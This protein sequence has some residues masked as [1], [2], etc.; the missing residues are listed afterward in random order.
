MPRER[1]ADTRGRGGSGSTI[2]AQLAD[3]ARPARAAARRRRADHLVAVDARASA[4]APRL[5]PTRRRTPGSVDVL[6]EER[7]VALGDPREEALSVAS[8]RGSSGR[9]SIS[10]PSAGRARRCARR[11]IA[12]APAACCLNAWRPATNVT[13][14][15]PSRSS[16]RRAGLADEPLAGSAAAGGT[17]LSFS[18][19]A[20]RTLPRTFGEVDLA[21]AELHPPGHQHVPA[22]ELVDDLPWRGARERD[23]V[24]RPLRHR[25][26]A[27]DELVVP[28]VLE[29]RRVLRDLL[30]RRLH[31]EAG[32]ERVGGHVPRLVD[33]LVRDRAG[34]S[35]D[36]RR[37]SR[38]SR[39][40][41]IGVASRTRLRT[42]ASSRPA[43]VEDREDAAEAV[44]GE[45][46]LVAAGLAP[47][48]LDRAR[49]VLV[50]VGLERVVRVALVGDAPVEHEDVEA[51]RRAGTR[52]CCCRGAD[53]GCSCG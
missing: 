38:P 12:R 53:R 24:A 36:R 3:V 41:S 48:G 46:H 22:D 51:L 21:P 8:S 25:L 9:I 11:A 6:L 26:V 32:V 35:S 16:S 10:A 45:R 5:R 52:P 17:T 20:L 7:A 30:R 23:L 40:K 15:P 19:T 50:D 44:A 39:V 29:Q 18:A 49:K 4:P 47:D 14:P 33:E 27:L 37:P 43:R 2:D 34:P 28:E 1:A 31:E 42:G 13:W